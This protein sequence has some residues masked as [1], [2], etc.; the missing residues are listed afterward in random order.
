M[1]LL[2]LFGWCQYCDLLSPAFA[3]CGNFTPHPRGS[4][5]TNSWLS[6]EWIYTPGVW[7]WQN[8][9]M[10]SW[11]TAENVSQTSLFQQSRHYDN[12]TDNREK[13]GIGEL[14]RRTF[15]HGNLP[16]HHCSPV[17]QWV[18]STGRVLWFK[19]NLLIVECTQSY[20][21]VFILL[22]SLVS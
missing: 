8:M 10:L 13:V 7:I 3:P 1:T 2:Q 21:Y 5:S 9:W 4:P 20:Q 19:K 16:V 18:K 6:V 14:P 17:R 22:G 15:C 11:K 12:P